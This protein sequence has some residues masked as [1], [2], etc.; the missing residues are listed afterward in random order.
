[1]HKLNDH[2]ISPLQLAIAVASMIIGIGILTLPRT[3]SETLNSP[4]GWI[5]ALIG[6]IIA[7]GIG[8]VNAKLCSYFPGQTFFEFCPILIGKWLGKLLAVIYIL[9]FT[10]F[11]C[12][13]LRMTGEVFKL[14]LLD[15]TPIEVIIVTMLL[16]STYL[17]YHGVNPVI[18][19][20]QLFLPIVIFLGIHV[21]HMF[22][23]PRLELDY[24]RPV[25]AE[26]IIPL[27]KGIPDTVFSYL[28]WEIVL[29]FIAFMNQPNKAVKMTMVGI[30]IPMVMYV[31]TLF[32][33][34]GIFTHDQVKTMIFPTME[35]A[36]VVE[37]PGLFFERFESLFIIIWI[38]TIFNTISMSY[39]L[40]TLGLSQIIRI[41]RRIWVFS[42]IPI[43]Y[44]A[45]L[46]PLNLNA[47]FAAGEWI[48][49]AGIIL[50]AGI[51]VLLL[52]L[53]KM[54]GVKKNASHT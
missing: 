22:A 42:L 38:M 4:D 8:A 18:R 16:L 2:S 41:N 20:N 29:F 51:P 33:I 12:Y 19:L 10:S 25:M 24:L 37:F 6:G 28:G 3:V 23:F 9:Y 14:Y 47:A 15:K 5:V 53:A 50:A 48:S 13:E 46:V 11:I 27:L 1:L 31:I 45:S 44:I 32:L 36:K 52:L 49:Y 7:M 21:I 26:G 43:F 35:L 17:V 40:V 54:R 30:A 39:Y 34:V